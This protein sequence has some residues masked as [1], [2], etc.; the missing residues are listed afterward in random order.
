MGCC[1]AL[2][3][4]G[5]SWG[6]LWALK[7]VT[8]EAEEGSRV[9]IIGPNGAG[10]TTLIHLISGEFRSSSGRILLRGKDITNVPGRRRAHLGIGRSFQ[11]TSLFPSLSVLDNM[12]LGLQALKPT[13]F[14]MFRPLTSHGYLFT[15]AQ[16]L[17]EEWNLWDKRDN[18]VK[19]LPYGEQ[20]QLEILLALAGKP[21][22]LL[23]DEP[24]AGLSV[25]ETQAFISLVQNLSRDMTLLFIEHDMDTAFRLADQI[26][27]LHQGQVIANGSP[28]EVRR[29]PAANEVYLGAAAQEDEHAAG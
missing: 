14:S 13:K 7:S 8:F 22:L 20:R 9:A 10:K 17:L 19:N 3:N 18:C 23:L 21:T 26:I 2:E 1:L 11:I 12:I 5:K 29:D 27:V 24:C 6:G 16:R 28:E 15:E 4:L 25:S